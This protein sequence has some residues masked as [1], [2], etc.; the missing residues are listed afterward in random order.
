MVPPSTDTV[1]GDMVPFAP[2]LAVMV[3]E[4]FGPKVAAIVWLAVMFVKEY[5]VTAPMDTPST[6]TSA[7]G[8]P[9]VG[10]RWEVDWAA[11]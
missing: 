8:Y 3:Y 7:S 1:P 10:V 4:G 5:V 9:A 2:A 11:L 6:W